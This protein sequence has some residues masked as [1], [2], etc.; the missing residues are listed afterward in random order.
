MAGRCCSSASALRKNERSVP[1][2]RFVNLYFTRIDRAVCMLK[3]DGELFDQACSVGKRV[4]LRCQ[5]RLVVGKIGGDGLGV[6]SREKWIIAPD[7]GR[8]E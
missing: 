3:G 1:V 2:Y 7:E 6:G 8:E 5:E 4:A